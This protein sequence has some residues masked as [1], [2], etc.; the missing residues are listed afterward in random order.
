MIFLKSTLELIRLVSAITN[1]INIR[2]STTTEKFYLS[3]PRVEIKEG[4]ILRSPTFHSESIDD[5][6]RET[7]RQL[8]EANIVVVNAYTDNRA[9]Y[10]YKNDM[11]IRI[12]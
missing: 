9:E 11:F 6:V 3:L 7:I 10:T 5:T 8:M 2:Y 4:A 1:D 12:N